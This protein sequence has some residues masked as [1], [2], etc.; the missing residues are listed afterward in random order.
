MSQVDV[1]RDAPRPK[2]DEGVKGKLAKKLSWA[3]RVKRKTVDQRSGYWRYRRR[4]RSTDER[5]SC[6][7]PVMRG[8]PKRLRRRI[9][10]GPPLTDS[11]QSSLDVKRNGA[12]ARRRYPIMT[13]HP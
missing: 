3:S 5:P 11:R 13:L 8:C 12:K 10:A 2:T 6:R 1:S 7:E 9:G 4:P